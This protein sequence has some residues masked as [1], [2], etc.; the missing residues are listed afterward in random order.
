MKS[1]EMGL[2]EKS[3]IFVEL[4]DTLNIVGQTD[5]AAKLLSD[6]TEELKGTPEESRYTLCKK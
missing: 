3:S 1:N 5:E 4:I 6:A 2:L